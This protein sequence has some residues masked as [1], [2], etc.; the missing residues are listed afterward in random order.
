[1]VTGLE[2]I[3][4]YH[5]KYKDKPEEYVEKFLSNS[6]E[7]DIVNEILKASVTKDEAS[8]ISAVSDLINLIDQAL[9]KINRGDKH[10]M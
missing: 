4:S 5:H 8:C 1:M 7:I 6:A 2:K 9:N 10:E 3:T